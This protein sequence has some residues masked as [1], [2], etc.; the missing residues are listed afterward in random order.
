[1]SDNQL[2]SVKQCIEL[3]RKEWMKLNNTPR[4]EDEPT[5][6]AAIRIGKKLQCVRMIHLL[7]DHFGVNHEHQ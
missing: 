1:M 4:S 5:R 7:S 3:I 6:D 2:D